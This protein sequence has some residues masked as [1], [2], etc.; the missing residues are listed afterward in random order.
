[1]VK[2]AVIGLTAVIL[3]IMIKP[4]KSEYAVMLSITACILIF[5][6]V[7]SRLTVILESLSQITEAIGLKETYLGLLLKIIGISY[8]GE[9]TSN[10]CKDSGYQAISGQIEMVGKITI[11]SMS[12]PVFLAILN[13]VEEILG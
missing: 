5:F 12:L 11:I 6:L 7:L 4:L 2:I 13:T 8:I 1:M 9:F 3:C 10:V